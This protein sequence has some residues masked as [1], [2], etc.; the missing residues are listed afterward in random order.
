MNYKNKIRSALVVILV[1]SATLTTAVWSADASDNYKNKRVILGGMPFGVSFTKGELRIKGFD[2]IETE[3]GLCSPAR[4]AGMLE[5]DIILKV[6]GKIPQSAV[7]VTVAVKE[8]GGKELSFSLR[9]GEDELALAV[10][11][12]L[13]KETGEWRLGIW[14][15]DTTAGL[16]TVTYVEPKTGEFGGL[17]HGITEGPSG[18]LARLGRGIVSEVNITGVTKGTVG[19][20]GELR[21][22]FLP[23][24]LGVVV[25]NKNEGVFGVL[26]KVPDKYPKKEIE[27]VSH[28]EVRNGGASILCTVDGEGICEYGVEITCLDESSGGT[29]NFLITVTDTSLI[30]KT[31]GIVRGMSG[32]PVVQNGKLVGAVTHVLV[33]DPCR[34]YGIFIENMITSQ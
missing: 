26:T 8:S 13:S 30:E 7:D 10:C 4:E 2:D 24:K 20:P 31:G 23:E 3:S 27:T 22:D 32:S 33:N 34:G 25:E 19:E 9:R 29:K 1:L 18:D 12:V 14:L 16:G 11:P 5:D 21:G 15:D 6:N 28:S 17:G